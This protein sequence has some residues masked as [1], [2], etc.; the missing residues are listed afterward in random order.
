MNG[1]DYIFLIIAIVSF[2]AGVTIAVVV[3]ANIL[4]NKSNKSKSEEILVDLFDRIEKD[5]KDFIYNYARNLDIEA[6]N[7]NDKAEEYKII[8]NTIVDRGFNYISS[9]IK[10]LIE[11]KYPDKKGLYEMI[12]SLVTEDRINNYLYKLLEDDNIKNIFDSI[13]NEVLGSEID[14]IEKEDKELNEEFSKYEEEPMKD[15]TQEQH[16]QSIEE[17]ARAH[18]QEKMDELNKVYD[19]AEK[20]NPTVVPVRD[21]RDL[22]P[23]IDNDIINPPSD[24]EPDVITDDGTIEIVEY[25]DDNINDKNIEEIEE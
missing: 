21:L 14:R 18:F 20:N 15:E 8:S 4:K 16:N 11:E 19:D 13:Y 3:I 17:F 6:Y 5:I 7:I 12:M 25:I 1:T 2:I 22:T 10:K 24:E 23:L 9:V